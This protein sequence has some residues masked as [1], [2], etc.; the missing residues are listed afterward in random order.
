MEENIDSMN[1]DDNSPTIPKD[2]NLTDEIDHEERQSTES[3][4]HKNNQSEHEK[5]TSKSEKKYI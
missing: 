5:I 3:L 1:I 2:V 4:I